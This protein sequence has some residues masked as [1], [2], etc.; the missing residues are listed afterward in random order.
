MASGHTDC[1]QL[2]IINTM[3]IYM[4]MLMKSLGK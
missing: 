3:L 2:E 4:I 1:N